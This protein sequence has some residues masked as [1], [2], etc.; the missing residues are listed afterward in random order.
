MISKVKGAVKGF[1]DRVRVTLML[2]TRQDKT[3]NLFP[4]LV[5]SYRLLI[6][7]PGKSGFSIISLAG[8]VL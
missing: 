4:G 1:Y 8:A 3:T 7:F 6:L 2:S 5:S